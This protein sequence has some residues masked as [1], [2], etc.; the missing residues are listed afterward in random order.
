LKTH[1]RRTSNFGPKGK[2]HSAINPFFEIERAIKALIL[3][4]IRTD[5]INAIKI[6]EM[7]RDKYPDSIS[8]DGLFDVMEA[9]KKMSEDFVKNINEYYHNKPDDFINVDIK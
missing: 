3:T 5:M 4:F 8:Q 2:E 6:A 7:K 9:Y 1:I